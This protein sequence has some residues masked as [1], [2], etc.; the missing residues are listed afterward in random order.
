M[1]K[2][3]NLAAS[4]EWKKI[5]EISYLDSALNNQVTESDQDAA[6]VISAKCA[7]EIASC[8]AP[9]VEV[10]NASVVSSKKTRIVM[11]GPLV[12]R[13][14]A[15]NS[16]AILKILIK[17]ATKLTEIRFDNQPRTEI[18]KRLFERNKIRKVT[19]QECGDFYKYIQTHRI[20]ELDIGIRNT[21]LKSFENVGKT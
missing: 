11:F 7:E 1:C 2:L 17:N 6:L 14:M 10:L 15:F 20:T 9:F 8:V 18:V 4:R 21:N 16:E 19:I 3:W 13:V 12:F 5:K